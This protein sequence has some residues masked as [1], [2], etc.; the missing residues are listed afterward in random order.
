MSKCVQGIQRARFERGAERSKHH[1]YRDNCD[2]KERCRVA[3]VAKV[4][5]DLRTIASFV[6]D[7]VSPVRAAP[8][9]RVPV[10]LNHGADDRDTRPEH[11]QRVFDALGGPKQLMLANES[12]NATWPAV[13][14]WVESI[15]GEGS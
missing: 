7:E 4:F 2:G 1:A 8:L 15:A 3:G 10:L 13:E 12:L 5:S 6:V 11:S 9:I 14:R